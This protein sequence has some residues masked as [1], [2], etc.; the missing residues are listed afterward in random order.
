MADAS[1]GGKCAVDLNGAKNVIGAF[2]QPK[3]ILID[4]NL[5]QTLPERQMHA[6]FSEIVKIAVVRDAG[7]LEA[8]EREG[9]TDEAILAA[10][11][12]KKEI[13]E[14]DEKESGERKLL[15]F[16]HTLGHAME[17]AANGALLHG[18]A[19]ALGML[20]MCEAPLRARLLA[21]YR[22]H[23]LPTETTLTPE[24]I[25]AFLSADKKRIGD[26]FAAILTAEAG[27]GKIRSLTREQILQRLKESGICL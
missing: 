16:G 4:P 25:G 7:L 19:V 8:L 10:V 27:A 17:S 24:Q 22:A 12:L 3:A 21:L 15:N 18:E 20:P 11:R 26:R 14:A 9:L 13:V 1:V 5:L 2:H 23:G 6:G